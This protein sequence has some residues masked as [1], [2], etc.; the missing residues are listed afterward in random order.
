MP[1]LIFT[2]AHLTALLGAGSTQLSQLAAS[3][4]HVPLWW[5]HVHDI[6][7]GD[8]LDVFWL[9]AG[10]W[11]IGRVLLK[12]PLAALACASVL[13]DPRAVRRTF[14]RGPR[15]RR[16]PAR[17]RAHHLGLGLADHPALIPQFRQRVDSRWWSPGCRGRQHR[18]CSRQRVVA[19]TG[20]GRAHFTF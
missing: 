3:G 6:V 9:V 19:S 7:P 20:E 13:R 17:Q 16:A 8:V 10:L 15:S 11:L 18:C 12:I 14:D 1:T 2:I 4:R 5:V